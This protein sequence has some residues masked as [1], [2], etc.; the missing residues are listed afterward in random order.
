[1]F[2]F[3]STA[4]PTMFQFTVVKQFIDKPP[5]TDPSPNPPAQVFTS[6]TDRRHKPSS[7][8]HIDLRTADKFQLTTLPSP[9]WPQMSFSFTYLEFRP[10][11][12]TNRTVSTHLVAL[13]RR[14]WQTNNNLPHPVQLRS[15]HWSSGVCLLS[16]QNL[17]RWVILSMAHASSTHSRS[18][19]K[20]TRFRKVFVVQAFN[21]K[22]HL[23][24]TQAPLSNVCWSVHCYV[25]VQWVRTLFC[26]PAMI[27]KRMFNWRLSFS[28][29]S[30]FAIMPR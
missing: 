25:Y 8:P 28:V 17:N 19:V 15:T 3:Q 2:Y 5:G 30:L 6:T 9:L 10:N 29:T 22:R 1:M 27:V 4:A 21:D 12:M 7:A 11:R 14:L 16:Y 18:K 23:L 24:L 26:S 13:T 20:P